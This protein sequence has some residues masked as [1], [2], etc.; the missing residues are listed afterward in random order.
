MTVQKNDQDINRTRQNSIKVSVD[1]LMCWPTRVGLRKKIKLFKLNATS[2][3][4]FRDTW[5]F[6]G[7]NTQTENLSNFWNDITDIKLA[8]NLNNLSI[9]V[10]E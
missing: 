2:V 10:D 8:Y 7:C 3:C 1:G 5:W 9:D 6:F 4:M